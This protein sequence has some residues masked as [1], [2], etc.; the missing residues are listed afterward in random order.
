ML[1]VALVVLATSVPASART[2]DHAAVTRL[3]YPVGTRS[4]VFVDRSRPTAAN[5]LYRA[6]GHRTL[7]TLIVYPARR[8]SPWLLSPP[9]RRGGPFPLVVYS[10]GYLAS[11][12]RSEAFLA[13]I[14]AHG[15]VVAAPTFPLTSATARGGPTEADVVNQPADVRVVIDGVLQLNRRPGPLQGLIDPNEIAAA[16]QSLGA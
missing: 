5:G 10:H 6:I 14:A 1:L 2:S 7:P 15:Y 11:G 9:A 12:P 8:H 16:G 4:V 3:S 13:R